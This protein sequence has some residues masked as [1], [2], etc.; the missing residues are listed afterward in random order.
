MNKLSSTKLAAVLQDAGAAI[1]KLASERDEATANVAA[2]ELRQN[3]DKLA[4][5][6]HT[7]G[8]HLDKS[9]DQLSV[10][11]EKQAAAGELPI[12]HRAVDMIAP[13]MGLNTGSLSHDDS[14]TAGASDFERFIFGGIG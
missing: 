10:E 2:M 14:K 11:L 3:I 1:R 5:Q 7:K 6:M 8:L 9:I 12:I 13:N 4:H